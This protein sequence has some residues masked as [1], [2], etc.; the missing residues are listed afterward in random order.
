MRKKILVIEGNDGA[1]KG[2]LI[3]QLTDYFK[4]KGQD[5]ILT[6]EP[7]GTKIS[8]KVRELLLSKDNME[9]HDLTEAYGYAM[10][11]IQHVYEKL[12][13]SYNS[14]ELIIC[15]RFALSSICYQGYGRM[16]DVDVIK[17]LNRY[18]LKEMSDK[19]I[20]VVL[21]VSPEIGIMR[22]KGQQELDRLELAGRTFHERVHDGYLKEIEKNEF[23]NYYKIDANGTADDTLRDVLTL[24][25]ELGYVN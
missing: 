6:R 20:N 22:K 11:R 15:D 12:V 9:M 17:D 10:A 13:P 14:D 16:A 18:A 8:E 21:V 2:T 4:S 5:V 25:E 24:L 23:G 19:M 3:A 7:G 1:G